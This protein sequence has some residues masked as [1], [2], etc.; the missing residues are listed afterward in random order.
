MEDTI[1]MEKAG[2]RRILRT[3]RAR[4]TPDELGRAAES[5]I[6]TLK[7]TFQ[8]EEPVLLYRALP[9]EIDLMALA[10][11]WLAEGRTI[12]FPAVLPNGKMLFREVRNPATDFIPGYRDILQP[13]TQCS[14]VPV[15]GALVLVPGLGFS[16]QGE[17][18]GRG[19]GYYDRALADAVCTTVGITLDED[20]FETL[21]VTGQ[22]ARMS[23]ICSEQRLIRCRPV[24]EEFP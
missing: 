16:R 3:R 6:Q 18:L 7:A 22:D 11:A 17:R 19:K 20:I 15:N 12:A 23:Y 4:R 2:L 10:E 14:P 8:R 13:D 21:P 5:I 9:D 1:S 24:T